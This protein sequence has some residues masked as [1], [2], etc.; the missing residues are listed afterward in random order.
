LFYYIIIYLYNFSV[1]KIITIIVNT[2]KIKKKKK[3]KKK[4]I[5]FYLLLKEKQ[6]L[7]I[8]LILLTNNDN[9]YN[10]KGFF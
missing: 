1:Y 10:E 2:Y 8:E 7:M 4:K 6:R 3:K 9:I 5:F